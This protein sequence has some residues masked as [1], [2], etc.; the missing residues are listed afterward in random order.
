METEEIADIERD[1]MNKLSCA[2]IKGFESRESI[3]EEYRHHMITSGRSEPDTEYHIEEE[4]WTS[5][6]EQQKTLLKLLLNEI[7]LVSFSPGDM[8]RTNST[9]RDRRP[10][11]DTEIEMKFTNIETE[12]N[13]QSSQFLFC[14]H[15]SEINYDRVFENHSNPFKLNEQDIYYMDQKALS[16]ILETKSDEVY[17]NEKF[18]KET[19]RRYSDMLGHIYN[20]AAT[21]SEQVLVD[22]LLEI[23]AYILNSMHYYQ[24]FKLRCELLHPLDL[25]LVI[26]KIKRERKK[27]HSNGHSLEAQ[28]EQIVRSLQQATEPTQ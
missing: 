2:N 1:I 15:F 8:V 7:D 3:V 5:F 19:F 17:T 28:T 13:P 22:Q 23:A 10:V 25:L 12:E 18:Q 14:K 4:T 24:K 11:E 6:H 27:D 20:H 16:W 26:D 21:M 9:S